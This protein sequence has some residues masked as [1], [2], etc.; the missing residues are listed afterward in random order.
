MKLWGTLNLSLGVSYVL[1]IV[2]IVLIAG[3]I[4]L[5]SLFLLKEDLVY[6]FSKKRRKERE[7][8]ES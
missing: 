3:I 4:Y 6:S 8:A 2:S 7:D 1:Q 5:V